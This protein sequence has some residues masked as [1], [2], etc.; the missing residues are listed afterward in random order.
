MRRYDL[1]VEQQTNVVRYLEAVR[2]ELGSWEIVERALP[3]AEKVRRR[4]AA[5]DSEVTVLIAWRLANLTNHSIYD[6]LSGAVLRPGHAV[7][8]CPHC[9]RPRPDRPDV[10][11]FPIPP[12]WGGKRHKMGRRKRA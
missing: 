4:I 2:A 5:G 10:E 1:S 12:A 3:I 7:N 11:I 9:R 8:L 6:I